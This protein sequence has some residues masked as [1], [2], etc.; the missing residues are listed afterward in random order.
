[1]D[2]TTE[3]DSAKSDETLGNG[4]TEQT[5]HQRDTT[6]GQHRDYERGF[7]QFE[8]SKHAVGFF[9]KDLAATRKKVFFKWATTTSIL[10]TWIIAVLSLYWAALYKAD[11]NL[12]SL[13]VYVV[14]METTQ[15]ALIGPMIVER[16]EKQVKENSRPHLG[17]VTVPPERFNYDPVQVRQ[18]V[19]DQ[20]AWV[21]IVINSN[22]T[23]L[24]R[25][26]VET[27]NSS[28]DPLGA[29]QITYVEARQD[30]TYYQ[31][32]YPQMNILMTETISRFGEM[33]TRQVLSNT[34]ISRTNLEKVP[35]ALSPAIGFSI[36]NLRPFTPPQTTP[37]V[38]VG[39]IY[40]IIIAFFS[41]TFYMPVHTL[42]MKKTP[43]SPALKFLHLIIWRLI[44][45]IT[46]YFFMSLAY[47][48]VSLAFQIP[49]F[50]GPTDQTSSIQYATKYGHASFVIYWMV[51]F[52]G[53]T[54]LGL[55][56]ENVAMVLGMPWTSFW[57]IFWV[58]TNVTTSFY[59]IET[60]PGFFY[61]GYAWPLHSIVEASRTIIFDLHSRIGLDFG[62]L[63]AWCGVNIILFPLCCM[64]F[65]K[66]QWKDL[67][68][69]DEE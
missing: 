67:D 11:D 34:S 26:A 30:T 1:M 33:W 9:H 58:I 40:L 38:T 19:Y 45:T 18:A 48:L 42:F 20:E 6:I 50:N 37:A 65:R 8:T 25:Q 21:S 54:A 46:A 52:V 51:N 61:W 44:S 68:V 31:L 35:Q 2:R 43:D 60:E 53:M 17:F 49:F 28:Y 22:A 23:T 16:T 39:L 27:G 64:W 29:C 63:L 55:A 59:A 69:K 36:F 12:N 47:S 4:Q 7:A 5:N 57:L 10:S 3:Q 13:I 24:L 15:D 32:I 14:N 41:F 62:I 56:C 66:K